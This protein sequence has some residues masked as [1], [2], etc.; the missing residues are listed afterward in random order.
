ME[1]RAFGN[2]SVLLVDY[3]KVLYRRR[4][5]AIAV[6]VAI[7]GGV[8]VF[9]FRATPLYQ[10]RVSV[11]IDYDE[12]NVIKFE[13]V[14]DE[15][16]AFANYFQTQ[17]ELLQSRTLVQ[18]TVAALDLWKRPE[19]GLA[20][21]E[22][23]IDAVRGALRILPIRGT[24]IVQIQIRW[25]D[26]KLAAEIANVHAGQYVEQS[27]KKRFLASSQATDWLDVQLAEERK[28]VEAA[29]SALQ[30]FR[31]QHDAVSLAEGQNIVV[32]KL[33]DLNAAVTRAKTNRI[34]KETQYFELRAAQRDT[35]ALHAF[36][37][38]L[39]NAFIQQLKGELS[40]LQ[41]EYAQLSE[42]L[43]DLHP[44]LVEKRTALQSTESRLAAEVARVVASIQKSYQAALADE[45]SLL[46]ALQ[47]QQREA[48]A[49]DRRGIQYSALEREAESVRLVYQS[50]LQRAKET[51]VSRE[52]RATNV[53][54]VDPARPP[55]QPVHP[56]TIFNTLMSM[57]TGL[58]LA[59][60]AAFLVEL[61]DDRIKVPSDVTEQLGQTFLGLVPEVRSKNSK[62]SI[63]TRGA[64][65][66]EVEAFR[67]LRTNVMSAIREDGP[68]TIL[69]TSTTQGEGKTHVASNLAVALAR[70][71]RRVL[72]L[73]ADMRR[74]SVHERL[75][76]PLEPGLSTVLT[77]TATVTDA[78]QET[79]I[80]GLNVL[81]AGQPSERAPELLGSAAFNELLEALPTQ[82]EWVIIDS[83][84]ALTVTDASIIAR[85]TTGVVFV[86][87]SAI[88]RSRAARLALGELQR[89]GG[90]ILGTV[91]NRADVAH[92]PFY[93]APYSSGGY[94]SSLE[95]TPGDEEQ[96]TAELSRSA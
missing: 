15:A 31:E 91:L 63:A 22:A 48:L 13:K 34:E 33:A 70:A 59:V 64:P 26:P 35:A 72:L 3:L 65:S 71:Q 84:P 30:A 96:A 68:R 53:R 39:S 55:K 79:E 85:R 94:L 61:V 17:H 77:S 66:V 40:M 80:P 81:T 4:W 62:G 14:F 89:A 46:R 50:L 27:L 7:V 52:L 49:L 69:I 38:I 83:P 60:G 86:V 21:E 88:A 76:R 47:E 95:P 92:H 93:F 29:E 11:L 41:R 44:T 23:A 24:R 32:Q 19:S 78:L 75:W 74:P 1:G 57:L 10:A 43:G 36:P 6:L 12:P 20:S 8:G 45:E 73:D 67:G 2:V 37:A 87:G 5:L 16:P 51:S 90:N 42:T 56:R 58:L 25:P 82:F 28:R 18:Q 54:I 9:T